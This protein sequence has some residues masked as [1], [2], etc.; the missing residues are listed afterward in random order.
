MTFSP[1]WSATS[2]GPETS[3]AHASDEEEPPET[4]IA[5]ALPANA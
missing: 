3:E 4:L 5:V 1:S 2:F